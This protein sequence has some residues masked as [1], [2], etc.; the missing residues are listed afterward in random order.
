MAFDP[1]GGL[2]MQVWRLAKALSDRGVEQTILTSHIPGSPRQWAPSGNTSIRSV[3]PWLPQSMGRWFLNLAW[4]VG[5]VPELVF[6]IRRYDL[7]HVH[8]N[9]SVWCRLI[10]LIASARGKPTIVSMNTALWGGLQDALALRGKPHDVA[11]A[12]ER[13]T[14][15]A[16]ERVLALT[17]A[18]AQ[19]KSHDMRL[20]RDK[21]EVIPDAIDPRR[22]SPREEDTGATADFRRTHGIPPGARVVTYVGRVS[23]EKGWEDLPGL[24]ATLAEGDVLLVCGDGPDRA[25]LEAALAA[26]CRPGT[27]HITGFLSPDHIRIAMQVADVLV[28]P[29]RREAFGGVLLE[30]MASGL[31]AVAYAHGEI[32]EVAGKPPAVCLVGVRDTN[33]L[34]GA[35]RNLL[36][37]DKKRAELVERGYRRVHDFSLEA[38]ADRVLAVYDSLLA[39][40]DDLAIPEADRS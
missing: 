34:A 33:G 6:G 39:A 1:V 8:F 25:R 40:S 26:S 22:F 15:T 11:A 24:A 7:V 20:E 38:I 17:A 37:D 32:A 4:F 30:A 31:P 13:R 19:R 21:F 12:I 35:V 29:S 28:L 27:W 18:D 5:V 2:Q 16:A 9:H 3:G 23:A 14:L 10:A 36:N